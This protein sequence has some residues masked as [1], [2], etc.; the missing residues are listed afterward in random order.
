MYG[1]HFSQRFAAARGNLSPLYIWKRP[2][3]RN[4][5]VY[6]LWWLKSTLKTCRAGALLLY[7][8][9]VQRFCTSLVLF[10]DGTKIKIRH[11]WA[12]SLER[13]R[14]FFQNLKSYFFHI[15]IARRENNT[16]ATFEVK[17]TSGCGDIHCMPLKQFFGQLEIF[18]IFFPS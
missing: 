15:R 8:L 5:L 13:N 6:P 17:W 9:M 16:L 10:L 7:N 12:V 11:L 14:T 4:G 2:L 3:K 18:K 1:V